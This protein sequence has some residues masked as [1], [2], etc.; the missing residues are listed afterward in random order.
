MRRSVEGVGDIKFPLD[1]AI[2]VR[3]LETFYS[4]YPQCLPSQFDIVLGLLAVQWSWGKREFSESA[5]KHC[6]AK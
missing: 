6:L 4:I 2:Y 1:R 5:V 3:E